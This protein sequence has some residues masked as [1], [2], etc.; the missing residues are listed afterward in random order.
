MSDLRTILEQNILPFVEKP[1]RYM[2]NELNIVR[3]DLSRITL[4]GV[5]CFPDL[6]DIGMSHLGLQILYHI[7]NSEPSWALSRCFHPWTDMEAKMRELG[8]PL[9][10]LEYLAPVREADWVGFTLQYELHATNLLNMLDLA[11]IPLYQRER[12]PADPLVI[13]GGPCSANPEP[14]ADFIDAFVIGDGEEAVVDLCRVMEKSKRAKVGREE[15]LA[16]LAA[17]TGVYVPSLFPTG[18]SGTFITPDRRGAPPVRAGSEPCPG[19]GFAR[20][21]SGG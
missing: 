15:T 1:L 16:A 13:A 5:F 20:P 14:L 11:G 18:K 10:S 12:G 6:Y 21:L 2:G 8:V 17:V 4:H 19:P 7:V 3:K 9:Y